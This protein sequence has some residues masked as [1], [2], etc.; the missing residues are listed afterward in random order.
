MSRGGRKG[1]RRN[2]SEE[3]RERVAIERRLREAI[4]RRPELAAEVCAQRARNEPFHRWHPYRQGFSPDLVRRFLREAKVTEGPVLDPFSGSGTTVIECARQGYEAVGVDSVLSLGIIA[5]SCFGAAPEDWPSPLDQA[6]LEDCWRQSQTR[7]HRIASLLALAGRSDGEGR[8]RRIAPEER[9]IDPIISMMREDLSAAIDTT[10]YFL[11]GDA[12]KLPL[13]DARFT[14]CLCSPP[15][16]SRYDYS[17]ISDALERLVGAGGRGRNRRAQL[18]ASRRTAGG[19]ATSGARIHPAAEEA[20]L[21]LDEGGQIEGARSVR[22]YFDDMTRVIDE[23]ARV[24]QAGAPL[25]MVVAGAEMKKHYVPAGLIL[26]E[27]LEERGFSVVGID[28]ARKLRE[29]GR[30]LGELSQV[31]PREVILRARRNSSP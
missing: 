2:Q 29:G 26:A 12:R 20:A 31:A 8:K 17:R 18:R 7:S 14:A 27:E 30:R 22:G 6:K 10:G 21:R 24:L 16:L 1:A 25:W 13:A 19:P 15:Y 9:P 3:A 11:R 28:E 4:V 23:L 5:S